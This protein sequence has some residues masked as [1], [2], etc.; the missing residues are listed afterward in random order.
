MF[1]SIFQFLAVK[2]IPYWKNSLYYNKIIHVCFFWS[3]PL[4]T[5][6]KSC[7]SKKLIFLTLVFCLDFYFSYRPLSDINLV[8]CS[9]QSNRWISQVPM[10]NHCI[11]HPPEQ[12]SSSSEGNPQ[13]SVRKHFLTQPTSIVSTFIFQTHFSPIKCSNWLRLYLQHPANSFLQSNSHTGH[14]SWTKFYLCLKN[15]EWS[16]QCLHSDG[17]W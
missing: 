2:K 14:I 12:G 5:S 10:S 1:C 9:S 7:F 4:T 11:L 8:T 15:Q 6:K 3:Q 13:K 17:I 16:L